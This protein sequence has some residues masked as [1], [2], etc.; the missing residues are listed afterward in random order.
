MFY[1][2]TREDDESIEII[3]ENLTVREYTD[4]E[5]AGETYVYQ[6]MAGGGRRRNRAE[7]HGIGDGDRQQTAGGG[8]RLAEPNGCS[9]ATRR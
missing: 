7:R 3:A 8:G 4:T 6:V 1:T 5:V 2:V 9:W